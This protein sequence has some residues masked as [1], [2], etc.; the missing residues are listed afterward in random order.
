[1]NATILPVKRV[2][3]RDSN[4]ALCSA[5]HLVINGRLCKPTRAI[6]YVWHPRTWSCGNTYLSRREFVFEMN[7]VQYRMGSKTAKPLKLVEGE[8]VHP[9]GWGGND[10]SAF[11]LPALN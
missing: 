11:V 6:G 9:M 2:V 3:T 1:M 4:N 7:G 5:L 10:S 8:I